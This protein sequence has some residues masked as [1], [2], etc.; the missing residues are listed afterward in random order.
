MCS[1]C[2]ATNNPS[3]PDG[4]TGHGTWGCVDGLAWT[5]CLR[6]S[7]GQDQISRT[8]WPNEPNDPM[9]VVDN[10]CP[11]SPILTYEEVEIQRILYLVTV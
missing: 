7:F 8:F 9:A 3:K 6:G 5:K 10:K 4:L 11:Q 2:T 1:N